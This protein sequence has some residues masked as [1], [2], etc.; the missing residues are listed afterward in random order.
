MVPSLLNWGRIPQAH[1]SQTQ[2][3]LLQRAASV[4]LPSLWRRQF[5]LYLP[6][7][8][9]CL[10]SRWAIEA[11]TARSCL[12]VNS[13]LPVNRQTHPLL[14]LRCTL[15]LLYWLRQQSPRIRPQAI[16]FCSACCTVPSCAAP[17][18]VLASSLKSRTQMANGSCYPATET[19]NANVAFVID[20]LPV[21]V[22]TT[23][24]ATLAMPQACSESGKKQRPT[25]IHCVLN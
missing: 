17:P 15:S 8:R 14:Q 22:S 10:S 20:G 4:S 2:E 6:H 25:P 3:G 7:D 23:S 21:F 16:C 24:L 11:F 5:R 1:P 18:H 12:Y 9:H 19:L 13:F